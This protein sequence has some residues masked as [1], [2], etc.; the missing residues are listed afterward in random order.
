[1][2]NY[3]CSEDLK[4]VPKCTIIKKTSVSSNSTTV[5]QFNSVNSMKKHSH[6]L[7]QFLKEDSSKNV[8]ISNKNIEG[9][10]VVSELGKGGQSKVF[11]VI[12]KRNQ[13]EK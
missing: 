4:E 10:E 1:M 8:A 13:N 5:S 6:K 3:C 12:I 11:E 7:L 9:I 2:G